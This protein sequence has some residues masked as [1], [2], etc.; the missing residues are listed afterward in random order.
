MGSGFKI[1][2]RWFSAMAAIDRTQWDQLAVPLQTP[3]LEW[4]WLHHLEASG[5]IAP[6]KGWQPCHLTVWDR[7]EMIGA[8]PLYI[9]SHSEGEFIF[10]H[11]WAQLARDY[12]IR[13][14]PKLVG[15][16]P[17]TPAVG[18]RFLISPGSDQN[19]VMTG[20]LSAID[21]FCKDH[22]LSSCHFNFVDRSW[23]DQWSSNGFVSWQHQSFMW[24]NQDFK[25]FDDYLQTFKSSQRRNI[26]R[27]RQRMK[28]F[29]ITFKAMTGDKIPSDM[30]DTMFQYYLHTNAR[31]GPWAARYL[32]QDFFKRIF[33][34]CRERLL[35][36]AAYRAPASHPLALSMLLIKDRHL[37]GRYWGCSEPV[38][39]LHF[40]MCFYAPIEWAID[41]GIQSFDPGA[42]SAH[43][44]YRGFQAVTNTSL[45]RLYDPRLKALFQH[46]IE[47]VNQLEISN[48]EALNRK[49]PFAKRN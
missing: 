21:G 11:W 5:S 20:M 8:A 48:V 42:G 33:Q 28:H 24:R 19:R 9:K 32:N 34:S 41:H 16:S 1:S 6:A 44:I 38:K 25:G 12:G 2:V 26:R 4:S 7:D 47:E 40:N 3:L 23:F 37:I 15:M 18:Y 14:Y 17:A 45:H 10:D 30:A 35:I 46:L 22:G 36:I 49:L 27:E 29:G 31:Y 43:K 39:D 13:Y